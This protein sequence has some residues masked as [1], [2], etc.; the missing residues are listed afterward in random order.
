MAAIIRPLTPADANA[1]VAMH[2]SFM[3][4]LEELGDPDSAVKH[5]TTERYLKDGFGPDPAFAGYIAEDEGSPC[6]YLLYCKGYNVDVAYRLFF[7]CD[8][9]VEPD[10]RGKGIGRR[11]VAACAADCRK[12][13]GEWLEWY[14]YRPNKMAFDFYRKLGA[15]ESD[16]LAVMTLR[17]DAL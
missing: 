10:A 7:I 8:L 17:A 3:A 14:V 16:A 9:W 11:L 4:Y 6:G 2:D 15:L 13:G 1:V 12:W 5:F